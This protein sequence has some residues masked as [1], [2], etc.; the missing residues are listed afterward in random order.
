[1]GS[2]TQSLCRDCLIRRFVD[3][4]SS[5]HFSYVEI[6]QLVLKVICINLK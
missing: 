5:T 6:T 2:T 1:M 4:E 3:G